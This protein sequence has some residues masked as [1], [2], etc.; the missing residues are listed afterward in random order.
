MRKRKIP[1]LITFLLLIHMVAS[2]Q[3]GLKGDYYDGDNFQRFVTTRMDPKI[4]ISWLTHPPVEG[5]NPRK[6]SIRWTG[7]L[8]APET[9]TYT[10]SVKVD[11]GVRVWIGNIKVIDAWDLH[12]SEDFKGDIVLEKG[13]FYDLKVEYYNGMIEGEIHLL[14]TLPSDKSSIWS[15][16]MSGEQ[17]ISP[18]YFYQ[19]AQQFTPPKPVVTA[20]IEKPVLKKT[21][22]PLSKQPFNKPKTVIVTSKSSTSENKIIPADTI[23]KFTP[24]NILFEQS[25]SVMLVESFAELDNLATFL[26]KYTALRL[27]I[28]GHTDNIGD[29]KLN[30]ILSEERAQ[31][32]KNYLVQKGITDKRIEA[33]GFGSTR[34]LIKETQT[35]GNV[36]NRRVEFIIR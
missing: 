13:K 14:W 1:T 33:K 20:V 15:Y 9:G 25:K 18:S 2:A 7:R 29:D 31:S 19:A 6:C 26:K 24:K 5:I 11:D 23:Q 10:F 22:P 4:D 28:E 34:P 21:V 35:I 27:T 12:D 30:L 16:F 32:V 3:Q 8:F 17:V 36:K